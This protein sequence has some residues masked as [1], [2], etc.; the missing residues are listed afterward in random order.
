MSQRDAHESY[1]V[2]ARRLHWVAAI[3]AV[4]LAGL[5]VLVY[6]LAHTWVLTT[7]PPVETVPP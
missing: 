1:A 7:S 4:G 2:A 5:G 3:L 6:G